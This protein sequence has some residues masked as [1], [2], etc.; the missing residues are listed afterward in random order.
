MSCTENANVSTFS[1]GRALHS[2][3]GDGVLWIG[4]SRQEATAYHHE[5]H[6]AL[7]VNPDAG[8]GLR[9]AARPFF[10]LFMFFMVETVLPLDG[11]RSSLRL[12]DLSE[13]QRSALPG[14]RAERGSAVRCLEKGADVSMPFSIRSSLQRATSFMCFMVDTPV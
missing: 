9:I 3:A 13:R 1:K 7:E 8:L 11:F 14:E 5:E 6:E 2:L 4:Y 12:C 10:A